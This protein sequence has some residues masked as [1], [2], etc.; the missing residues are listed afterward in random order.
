MGGGAPV[1]PSPES[2]SEAVPLS[3]SLSLS[4]SSTEE[5]SEGLEDLCRLGVGDFVS[6]FKIGFFGTGIVGR[7]AWRGK[8]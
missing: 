3:L 1:E 2:D 6:F 4:F 5:L 7:C 8:V